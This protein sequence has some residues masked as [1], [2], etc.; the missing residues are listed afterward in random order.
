MTSTSRPV[1]VLHGGGGPFTVA[2]IAAHV[3]ETAIL[4]TH[5]GWNGVPRPDSIA[6]IRDLA[7]H[8][9]DYLDAND[10]R[11]VLVVGSSL[12]GW[13][14]SE[15]ALLTDR[16]SGL[17]IIDGAGIEVPGEPVVDFFSLDARG[18]AEHS[19]HDSEKFFRDPALLPPE[20]VA[21][22][23][24]NMATMAAIA[25]NMQDPTLLARLGAIAVPTLVIWGESDRVFTPGYGRAYAAAIPGARFELVERAGHLPQLE[26][27]EAVYALL[28]SMV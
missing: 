11:D 19:F 28:D 25:G 22:Q 27:P 2:G 8:Y 6:S 1:L 14:A 26:Q 20:Q 24:A 16:V 3:G 12:G 5:P 15:L 10:L 21:A 13:A 23:K 4:P 18:V 17:V 9:R 7:A